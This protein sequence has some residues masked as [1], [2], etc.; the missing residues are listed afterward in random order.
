MATCMQIRLPLACLLIMLYCLALF[1]RKQ[2]LPTKAS[3]VFSWMG[4]VAVLNLCAATAMEYAVNNRALV[5]EGL[6]LVCHLVFFVTLVSWCGLL[7]VY[8]LMLIERTGGVSQRVL[9]MTSCVICLLV[10][11]AE[12]VLPLDYVDTSHGSYSSGPKVYVL[13]AMV[14]FTIVTLA[15]LLVRHRATL[16][17]ANG[18]VFAASLVVLVVALA[19]Q[20][21]WPH[22]FVTSPALVMV[23]IG[24]MVTMEDARLYVSPKTGLYNFLACS[25]ILQEKVA[26]SDEIELGCYLFFGEESEVMRV[27]KAA[28]EQVAYKGSGLMCATFTDSVLL[29]LSP[30]RWRGADPLPDVLPALRGLGEDVRY[31]AHVLKL[32]DV[33]E[34]Q[35]VRYVL[36]DVYNHFW[37]DCLYLDELTH[38]MRR[39][40]F[41]MQVNAMIEREEPFSLL[42]IDL[43]DLKGI[44]DTYGHAMGD[45]VLRN[46]ARVFSQVIRSSDIACRMGG[47]EFAI[48]ISGTTDEDTLRAILDRIEHGLAQIDVL[49][50]RN[51]PVSVSVGVRMHDPAQG[52]VGFADLYAQADAALYE[53]KRLGKGR[54]V[55]YEPTD[56]PV[57]TGASETA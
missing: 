54:S 36:R 7:L 27:M 22:V 12:L 24:L 35:Q 57:E 30:S 11:C 28:N 17:H 15:V 32:E 1:L 2:R 4:F 21:A 46:V 14:M 43:D 3:R 40:A 55:F 10:V 44:N 9:I 25:T 5:P 51:A 39:Q 53:A 41:T 23:M 6:N 31:E 47:D 29:V 18:M 20:M 49:P 38:L 33:H 8:L 13:Y 48:A 34:I 52:G 56:A 42:M 37:S 26:D 19:V 45:K 50:E 16:G